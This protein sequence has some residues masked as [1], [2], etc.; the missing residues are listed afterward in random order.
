MKLLVLFLYHNDDHY[1][2]LRDI[3]RKYIHN[4]ENIDCYFYTFR[5]DI[6]DNVFID[7]DTVYIKGEEKL[8][9]ITY[10]T[11]KAIEFLLRNADYDFV[12]RTNVG[13]LCNLEKIYHYICTL[14]TIDVYTGGRI[15]K[16]MVVD[17]SYGIHDTRYNG[18]IYASGT[19]IILSRDVALKL[20][21]NINKIDM[22]IIDDVTIAIYIRKYIQN[23]YSMIVNDFKKQSKNAYMQIGFTPAINMNETT[24]SKLIEYNF[25][26]TQYCVNISQYKLLELLVKECNK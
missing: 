25:V 8:M 22:S 10:K 3:Q 11:I 18:L 17:H 20:C 19:S 26:R 12:L 5:S 14:P 2:R 23:A 1:D 13:T 6:S 21:N 7:N 15:W 9:N 4:F 24:I 16:Q